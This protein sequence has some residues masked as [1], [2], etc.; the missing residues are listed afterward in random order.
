MSSD[1][2]LKVDG[3]KG[4]STHKDHK[5]EIEVLSWS[6][7]VSNASSATSGGGSGRGKAVASD[8]HFTHVYDKA[9]PVL[10]QGCATGKHFKDAVLTC[11]KAGGGQQEY[12]K[13]T[14]KEVFITSV[15]FGGSQGGETHE[16]V[17]CS[18][19]D[20]EFVYKEQ[21]DK[22]AGKGDVK[23]GW[24]FGTSETR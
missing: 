6:W 24:N 12:L 21:D 11:R 7:S 14:M 17:S 15:S 10:S 13:V 8:F 23:F 20:I 22:G 18:C 3:V 19:K 5:D 16:Q 1:F 9:S 2:S 4:E